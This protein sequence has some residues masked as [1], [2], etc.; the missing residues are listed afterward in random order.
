MWTDTSHKASHLHLLVIHLEALVLN[1]PTVQPSVGPLSHV[2]IKEYV[3][4]F[5]KILHDGYKMAPNIFT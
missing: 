5:A 2:H 3:K 4:T 1:R